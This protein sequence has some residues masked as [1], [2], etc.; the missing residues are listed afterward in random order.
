MFRKI[1]ITIIA[2]QSVYFSIAQ[3]EYKN[4]QKIESVQNAIKN[5]HFQPVEINETERKEIMSLYLN[6]IDDDNYFFT[7]NDQQAFQKIASE[8]GLCDAFKYSIITYKKS[9]ERYDSLTSN[10]YKK[11]IVLKKGENL[12]SNSSNNNHL[13]PVEK[14][15]IKQLELSFKLDYLNALNAKFGADSTLEKKITSK[16]D[17]DIRF[18]L[19]QSEKKFITRK[20]SNSQDF[21]T[22]LM[23]DFLN[24]I[25]LRFDPHSGYFSTASK[26]AYEEEL[27]SERLVYGIQFVENEAFDIEVTALTPGSSAWNSN[28]ILEGDILLELIDYK[29]VKHEL[30]NKGM[31][32]LSQILTNPEGKEA[33]FKVKHKNGGISQ[34]KLVKTKVENTDNSFTGYVLKDEKNKFGYIALPSFYTDFEGDV[35]LGCANDVAKEI[36]L[37]KKDSIQGLIL[38][39]RNN[40]G[41]SLKEAIELSGLFIDE[42]PMSIYQPKTEKPYLLKDMNRGT[43]YNGPLIVLVNSMS[44][45]ASE[46]FAGCMQDYQRALIV[47]DRTYGK[48]TAQ[49]IFPVSQDLNNEDF[50]KVTS[51]KFYH[52]SSRSNQELGIIPDIYLEDVYSEIDY[53]LESNELYHLKNDST[54]KKTIFK[55]LAIKNK[56]VLVQ[57]SKNRTSTSLAFEQIKK[58]AKSLAKRVQEDQKIPLDLESF[59]VYR[60][61]NEKFW[62]EVYKNELLEKKTFEVGNHAFA[63]KLL[64]LDE[65]EQKF[66]QKIKDGIQK[67]ILLHESFFILKDFWSLAQ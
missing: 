15:Y 22:D 39:L 67:D 32:Y 50:V 10:F 44:A 11:A 47:G 49:S 17:E 24:A 20:L 19:A 16:L 21:E 7:L 41:G 1:L 63:N 57:N 38:D 52:V 31:T 46:F 27:S 9:L 48:G 51:G 26:E 54:S 5:L 12:I 28:E 4:C 30:N 25:A 37:L 8:K 36:I 3:D 23:N 18:K 35:Q 45:S 65:S 43:V 2:A 62:D 66:N 59:L 61:E 14:D 40:G 53:Y 56:N 34:V 58:N 42:G 64:T 6:L 13:R 29:D 33:I 55:A 60:S